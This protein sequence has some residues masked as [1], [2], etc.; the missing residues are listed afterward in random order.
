MS[1]RPAVSIVMPAFNEAGRI[2][3]SLRAIDAFART[4]ETRLE[5]IVVDDGSVDETTSIAER[6]L[7]GMTSLDGRVV[8][9]ARNRGKGYAVR[10]G[11]LSARA[12][13]ALFTDA[14]LSTPIQEMPRLVGDLLAD[15][16]DLT[17]GSRGIDRRL[18]G[19]HQSR[20]RELAGRVFNL[21]L[22]AATGLPFKD[23][24]CGFKAFRMNVC[25]PLIEAGRIDGFGFDVELL[26]AAHQAGLRL[27]EIP[28]RWDHYEG[29]K[30]RCLRDG[31]RMLRDIGNI[32]RQG[33]AGLYDQGIQ[34]ASAALR[35]DR[36]ARVGSLAGGA[37]M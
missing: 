2:G 13:V 10:C 28:V 20:R 35:L 27:R 19:V 4:I 1:G 25:R 7:G 11:L 6:Y 14:D 26:Y 32:R 8:R 34:Q 36:A 17:F 30:V 37:T 33:A 29:S 3:E 24:Q 15:R 22:R 23:T 12:P 16:A 18:I 31:L 21:V 9:Y 5:L